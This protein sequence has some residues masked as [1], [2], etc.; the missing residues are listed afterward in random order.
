MLLSISKR[1]NARLEQVKIYNHISFYDNANLPEP[2]R[3]FM[4]ASYL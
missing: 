1:S 3:Y 2:P 4:M